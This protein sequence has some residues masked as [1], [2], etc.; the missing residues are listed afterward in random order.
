[1]KRILGILLVSLVLGCNEENN[2]LGN[3]YK[4]FT[5]EGGY[6]VLI[7][8][9]MN[10]QKIEA[11]ILECK[12]DSNFIIAIQSPPDS[13]PPMKKIVY[14]D[15]DRKEIISNAKVFRQYWIINKREKEI[16]SFDSLT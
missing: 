7:C 9:S 14:T 13:L 10:I 5:D 4:L 6:T 11:Y 2:S 15:S 3:G 8:D 16:Y 1:M 12:F